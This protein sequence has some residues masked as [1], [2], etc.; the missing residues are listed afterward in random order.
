MEVGIR[1]SRGLKDMWVEI[2]RIK[3]NVIVE[4]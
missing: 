3:Y 2:E 1:E 4:K